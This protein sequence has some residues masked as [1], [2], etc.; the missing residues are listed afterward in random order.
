MQ[1]GAPAI[2]CRSRR[3]PLFSSFALIP[4]LAASSK[5]A[6]RRDWRL[7]LASRRMRVQPRDAILAR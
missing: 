2:L 7:A 1:S 4:P 6:V 5:R 3:T